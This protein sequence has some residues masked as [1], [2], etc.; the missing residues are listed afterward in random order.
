M[1]KSAVIIN[2]LTA[3][4][5]TGCLNR[6][7]PMVLLDEP[8][9]QIDVSYPRGGVMNTGDDILYRYTDEAAIQS[10]RKIMK[11]TRER[12]VEMTTYPDYEIVVTYANELPM[13]G[14]YVWLGEEGEESVLTYLP[15]FEE[16]YVTNANTTKQ[17]RELVE[18]E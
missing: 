9:V 16:T 17:L 4:L 11:N 12:P 14:V 5:L 2:L 1:K 6:G 8:I 10:F 18:K 7:E 13:H 3:L 15:N